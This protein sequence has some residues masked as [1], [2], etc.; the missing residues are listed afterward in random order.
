VI[1]FFST[2]S[3]ITSFKS[4]FINVEKLVFLSTL[5]LTADLESWKFYCK[6]L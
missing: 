6:T 1:S 3:N 4:L 5:V 2:K